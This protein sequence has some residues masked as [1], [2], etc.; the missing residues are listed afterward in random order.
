MSGHF[1]KLIV[2]LMKT[3]G[4]K[5]G[6]RG[7][8]GKTLALFASFALFAANCLRFGRFHSYFEIQSQPRSGF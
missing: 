8:K 1:Y 7:K 5:K 3:V 2:S 6:K 4:C